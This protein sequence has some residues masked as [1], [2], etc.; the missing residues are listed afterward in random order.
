MREHGAYWKKLLDAGSVIVFGPV[1]DPQG[2]WGLGVVR[3]AD[4]AAVRDLQNGDPVMRVA[5]FRYEIM[6]MHAAVHRV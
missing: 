1:A 3:A 2:D 6:P 4:E 5:G